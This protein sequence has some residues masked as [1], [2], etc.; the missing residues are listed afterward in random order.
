MTA[1]LTRD[2][3]AVAIRCS[4]C[5]GCR[6]QRIRRGWACCIQN[7]DLVLVG[8]QQGESMSE[9]GSQAACHH[10]RSACAVYD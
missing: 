8:T 2:L 6:L 5:L 9:L 4:W 3:L 7:P 1:L 10:G